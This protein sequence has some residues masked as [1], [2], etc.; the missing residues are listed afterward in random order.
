M[1]FYKII[2]GKRIDSRVLQVTQEA[3][4]RNNGLLTLDD[5]QRI[6]E[7]VAEDDIYTYAEK[8]TVLYIL[9][10]FKWTEQASLWIK[11]KLSGLSTYAETIT[12]TPEELSKQSFPDRDV[13]Y[14]PEAQEAR[15]HD[16]KTAMIET[17]DNHDDL[18]IIIRLA[19]GERAEVFCNFIEVSDDF[20]E[21]KGGY[22][23]PVKAIER[24]EI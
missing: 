2:D 16:L 21:L 17:G 11:S 7:A 23:V 20:V 9:S 1:S 3:A 24:V 12:M 19:S 22:M 5:A 18:G 13:L 4:N 15:M 8:N 6:Y 14:T 10:N